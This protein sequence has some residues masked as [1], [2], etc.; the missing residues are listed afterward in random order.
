MI[1]VKG[2]IWFNVD[3]SFSI[4]KYKIVNISI[5]LDTT[6]RDTSIRFII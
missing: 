4:D 1:I 5:L 6:I 3:G 2:I